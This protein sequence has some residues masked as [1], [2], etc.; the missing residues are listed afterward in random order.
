[1]IITI[2]RPQVFFVN[3]DIY[4]VEL[5]VTHSS[6]RENNSCKNIASADLKR[7]RLPWKKGMGNLNNYLND[8]DPFKNY[9]HYQNDWCRFILNILFYKYLGILHT[10]TGWLDSLVTV[11]SSLSFFPVWFGLFGF[12][13]YQPL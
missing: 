5:S 9:R 2:Q 4:W 11:Y 10:Y 13:A 6:A 8:D 7:T 3:V 1:M 12:M